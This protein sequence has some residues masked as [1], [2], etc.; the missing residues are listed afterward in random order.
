M[1]K[2]LN[3]S[4]TVTWRVSIVL[5][6]TDQDDYYRFGHGD[7]ILLAPDTLRLVFE[8]REGV[9]G[10]WRTV[11]GA[12]TLIGHRRKTDDSLGRTHEQSTNWPKWAEKL[13]TIELNTLREGTA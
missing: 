9:S 6:V 2:E 12:S 8:R 7:S 11:Y 13:L 5:D 1:P 3:R 4:V 10:G